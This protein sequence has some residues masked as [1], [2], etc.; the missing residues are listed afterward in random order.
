MM[1]GDNVSVNRSAMNFS[2]CH[3]VAYLQ[4]DDI[5]YE[6]YLAYSVQL[7]WKMYAQDS[8]GLVVAVP[9]IIQSLLSL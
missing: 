3:F 6:I 5:S 8:F 1:A 4:V 2:M 7:R 9:T